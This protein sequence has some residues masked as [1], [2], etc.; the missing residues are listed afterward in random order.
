MDTEITFTRTTAGVDWVELKQLLHDDD[1]D[2]GR[3]PK[4]LA[5]SFESSHAV[6]FAWTQ[7]KVIG[8]ARVL[9]D[10]VC[11]A[12]LVDVWTH[13][14]YRRAGIATAMVRCLLEDL[15]GQHVYLQAE[16]ENLEFYRMLGF[17]EQPHGLSLVVGQWL[18]V[19]S[20]A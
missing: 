10:G 3:S 7:G 8:K 1:F 11:N 9:S 2:N 17:R 13:S 6:C 5:V 15:P 4:Q 20:S 14:A 12:Y 18:V 16:A 19:K